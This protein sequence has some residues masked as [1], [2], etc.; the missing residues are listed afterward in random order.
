MC[1]GTVYGKFQN[2]DERNQRKSKLMYRY[3]MLMGWKTSY[4]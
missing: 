4:C 2:T 3:M 1:A